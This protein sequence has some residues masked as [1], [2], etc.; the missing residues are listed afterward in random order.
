M[1][2][3]YSLIWWALIGLFRSRTSLQ[4]KILTVRHQLNVL[5][6]KSPQRLTFTSID[7][8][9]HALWLRC[10]EGVE[11]LGD[12]FRFD[13]GAGIL[14]RNEY[15]IGPVL[16]RSYAKFAMA[17]CHGA[18][19]LDSVHQKIHYNFVAAGPGRPRPVEAT[20]R[21]GVNP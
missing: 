7:R 8:L 10:E 6:R 14:H 1:R 3:V 13:F 16:A 9:A 18:H 19:G 12:M 4:A 15:L 2:D 5:R 11:Q 20:P 17:V 21:G